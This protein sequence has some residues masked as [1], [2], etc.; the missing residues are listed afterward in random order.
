M[1]QLYELD[2]LWVDP[3]HRGQGIGTML[4]QDAVGRHMTSGNAVVQAFYALA[5]MAQT[6]WWLRNATT[7]TA[8]TAAATTTTNA[9][10]TT[11]GRLVGWEPVSKRD[12]PPALLSRAVTSTLVSNAMG[13]RQAELVCLKAAASATRVAHAHDTL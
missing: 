11:C 4:V 13:Q 2:S 7:S 3:S 1:Q 9:A 8:A 6:D 12:I 10:T 5:P